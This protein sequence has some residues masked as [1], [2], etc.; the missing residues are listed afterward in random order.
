MFN[1]YT[2]YGVIINIK[3]SGKCGTDFQKSLFLRQ[4]CS[5]VLLNE[6]TELT[7]NT[8]SVPSVFYCVSSLLLC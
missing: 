8:I 1:D 3:S 4:H 7:K 2:E 5:F 6:F